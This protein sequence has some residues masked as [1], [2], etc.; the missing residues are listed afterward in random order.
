MMRISS[1][2]LLNVSLLF[3]ISKLSFAICPGKSIF[4][5]DPAE[6][7]LLFSEEHHKRIQHS[8][9]AQRSIEVIRLMLVII[10]IFCEQ[11]EGL[12]KILLRILK[13]NNGF[14][15]KF[16]LFTMAGLK[17]SNPKLDLTKN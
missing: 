9:V 15:P 12:A 8:K 1:S 7:N 3:S 2:T 5:S 10:K 14:A 11:P 4:D 16:R 13:A 6:G 17:F